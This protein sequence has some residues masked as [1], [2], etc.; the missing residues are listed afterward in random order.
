MVS[1]VE[2]YNAIY[3]DNPHKWAADM[4]NMVAFSILSA[5]TYMPE[6]F[7]DIG[8]GNGHT[9]EYFHK[10]WLDTEYVGLD[11]SDVAIELARKRVP[12]AF[13]T[14]SRFE[15]AHLPYADVVVIMGVLE[16]FENLDVALQYL[17]TSG[18][19]IYVECPNCLGYSDSRVEGFRQTHKGAGQN[20]W[21]LRRDTWEKRLTRAG[22]KIVESIQG[23]SAPTE[24]IWV[25]R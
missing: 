8:C 19:V 11:L 15:D 6:V 24:F 23:F 25:L 5:H 21:H 16:H 12:D 2:L 20:E 13:F 10:R 7:L 14:C 1:E 4:R 22:F 17:K 3:T 9:I 18:D